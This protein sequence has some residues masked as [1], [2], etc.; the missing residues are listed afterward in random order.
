MNP[1]HLMPLASVEE[2]LVAGIPI[3]IFMIPIIA[4]LTHH[5]RKMAEL[6]HGRPAEPLANNPEVTALRH[7]VYELKQLVQQQIISMDTM[8]AQTPP[9]EERLENR[10]G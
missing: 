9:Q 5:Q 8:R 1:V 6:I 4:I 2:V 7:E 10:L 3:V